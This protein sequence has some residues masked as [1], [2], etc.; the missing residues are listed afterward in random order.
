MLGNGADG[1][2][3]RDAGEWLRGAG[4]ETWTSASA[5]QETFSSG[6]LFRVLEKRQRP[7]WVV[8]G[9]IVFPVGK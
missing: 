1:A 9:Q 6:L 3:D 7:V 8:E 2:N 4:T 5:E